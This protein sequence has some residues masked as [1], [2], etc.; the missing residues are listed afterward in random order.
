[1]R[2]ALIVY[3]GGSAKGTG[4]QCH[5]LHPLHGDS[6]FLS[7]AWVVTLL[8]AS[9]VA[10][11]ASAAESR[12]ERR[13]FSATLRRRHDCSS[14][15]LASGYG[16]GG[17][18][19]ARHRPGSLPI[20]HAKPAPRSLHAQRGVDTYASIF[21]ARGTEL[22]LGASGTTKQ[23]TAAAEDR[24]HAA[25]PSGQEVPPL[26]TAPAARMCTRGR[27]R[28]QSGTGEWGENTEA[29]HALRSEDRESNDAHSKDAK[30]CDNG[31]HALRRNNLRKSSAKLSARRLAGCRPLHSWRWKVVNL[32]CARHQEIAPAELSLELP[33]RTVQRSPQARIC[34]L[35]CR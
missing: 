4:N 3:F 34:A 14:T 5:V 26:F 24:A 28:K 2:H 18:F 30:C 12:Q 16:L 11:L 33:T 32:K 13:L 31:Y 23:T 29:T 21:G 25:I 27:P 17:R 20:F 7:R 8:A 35:Q 1:M 19:M 6:W 15:G 9:R 22:R 10:S